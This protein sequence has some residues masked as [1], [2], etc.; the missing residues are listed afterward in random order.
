MVY[1]LDAMDAYNRKL[2]KKIE[3]K[4]ISQ[5]GSTATNGFVYLDEIVIGKG[6]PQ[7][8]I[9]FDVKTAN[10]FSKQRDWWVR[11]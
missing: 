9:S 6:N 7:A 4:G 5:K 2:V 3:V 10:G 1:R 8:R 11:I